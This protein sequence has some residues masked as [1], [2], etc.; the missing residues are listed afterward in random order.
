MVKSL[1]I[2]TIDNSYNNVHDIEHIEIDKMIFLVNVPI[3]D[4]SLTIEDINYKGKL[5]NCH[6]IFD[7]YFD[8]GYYYDGP[9]I[10][11]DCDNKLYNRIIHFH[12]NNFD[13]NIQSIFNYDYKLLNHRFVYKIKMIPGNTKKLILKCKLHNNSL[14]GT[15]YVIYKGICTSFNVKHDKQNK[16]ICDIYA[17]YSFDDWYISL[18]FIGGTILECK[19]IL[20]HF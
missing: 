1:H 5:I 4:Y 14:L 2:T 17:N 6:G 11:Y 7:Y 18:T 8:I 16:I 10:F 15:L 3:G 9:A 12:N 19:Q 20:S 13:S